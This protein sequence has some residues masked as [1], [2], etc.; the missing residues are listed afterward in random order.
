MNKH[1]FH[2]FFL[3]CAFLILE[4]CGGGSSG[5][6]IGGSGETRN[7]SGQVILQDGRI[8]R[9]VRVS[10]LN[11][12]D[13]TTTDESGAFELRS[14]VLDANPTITLVGPGGENASLEVPTKG[15]EQRRVDLSILF[16]TNSGSAQLLDL[17][18]RAKIVR[19]CS[20][21]FIN[22]RTIRQTSA[23]TEGLTCVVEAD[24]RRGGLPTNDLVF[25][26]QHR[27]CS[28]D[29]PWQFSGV[30]KTGTSGPG[31]GEIEF[32]FQNDSKHC[33]YR[34]VG[35]RNLNGVIELSAQI[36]TLRKQRFDQ[37]N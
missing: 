4:G 15:A 37:N 24:F 12:E 34:I 36:N 21:F 30:S 3:S 28:P 6:A 29:E 5:T 16:D 22:T 31:F 13:T 1:I 11:S 20:T 8:A 14:E 9:S 32:D 26:L 35:P 27:G 33:V 17:T 18:L 2:L 7:F 23:I 10:L 19:S 25:E